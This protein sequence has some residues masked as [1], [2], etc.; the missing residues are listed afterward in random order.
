[1]RSSLQSEAAGYEP[2]NA[3]YGD[4]TEIDDAA[5]NHI[6]A[7]YESETIT[8][9][10]QRGDVLILDNMLTAHGRKPDR[11]SRQIVVGMGRLAESKEADF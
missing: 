9:P 6:R 3:F 1:V 5:L 11:G 10:W 4:G 8:F 2:R 7:V